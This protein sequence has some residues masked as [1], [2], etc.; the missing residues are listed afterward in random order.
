VYP[1]GR[2]GDAPLVGFAPR[3]REL[4]LYVWNDTAEAKSLAKKLGRHKTSVSCLYIRRLDDVDRGVLRQIAEASIAE[5]RRR[6]PR[7]SGGKS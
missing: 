4:V 6:Y 7:R 1:S 2:E 3:G 5:V